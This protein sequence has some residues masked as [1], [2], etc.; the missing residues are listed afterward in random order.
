MR[1]MLPIILTVVG[2]TLSKRGSLFNKLSEKVSENY[3]LP[4][5]V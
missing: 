2:L 4:R 3:N 1:S 5:H